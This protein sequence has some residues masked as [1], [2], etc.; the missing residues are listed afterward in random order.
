MPKRVLRRPEGAQWLLRRWHLTMWDNR[1][2]TT[3]MGKVSGLALIQKGMKTS[4]SGR[5]LSQEA[6]AGG[7]Q[8]FEVSLGNNGDTDE[9]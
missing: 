2:L 8:E 3:R 5:H 1:K 4:H 7:A 9:F 6:E